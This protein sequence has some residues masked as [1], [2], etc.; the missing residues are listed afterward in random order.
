[1]YNTLSGRKLLK[2]TMPRQYMEKGVLVHN[3]HIQES[4]AC[5]QLALTSKMSC[6]LDK[7]LCAMHDG[8]FNPV[9]FVQN[10]ATR[11]LRKLH[12]RVTRDAQTD[13]ARE[14]GCAICLI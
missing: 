14:R 8:V 10:Y 5:T 12:F 11:G 13:H 6:S 3:R 1:M 4:A 9:K 2:C 7:P